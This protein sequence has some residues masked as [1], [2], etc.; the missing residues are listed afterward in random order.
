MKILTFDSHT[1]PTKGPHQT[2][3]PPLGPSPGK[4]STVDLAPGA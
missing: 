3:K 1:S 2:P 4:L